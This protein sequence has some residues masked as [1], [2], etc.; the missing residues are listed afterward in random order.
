M[1]AVFNGGVAIRHQDGEFMQTKLVFYALAGL[2]MLN[3]FIGR[4]GYAGAVS[5]IP[6]I[7]PTSWKIVF[8]P[9]K[10]HAAMNGVAT[11]YAD[12][13]NG[14]RTASGQRFSQ[15]LLTAAHRTLPFGT[16]V[17]VTNVRSQREVDVVINDRGA[18]YKRGRRIIDLSAAAA[19]RLGMRKTGKALV[20]LEILP[21]SSVRKFTR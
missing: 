11:V 10:S 13:F 4:P 21:R 7:S 12:K 14:R 9:A 6:R 19:E 18:W 2:T 20:R 3:F 16:W 15:E 17:R 1:K 5:T 8:S